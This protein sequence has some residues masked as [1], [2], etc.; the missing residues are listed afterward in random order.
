MWP[1]LK[2][3]K[4]I[5]FLVSSI[6]TNNNP[7]KTYLKSR[8]SCTLIMSEENI[9]KINAGF[10]FSFNMANNQ[11]EAVEIAPPEEKSNKEEITRLKKI[12]DLFNKNDF[13]Q[14][15]HV[16]I[17]GGD[18]DTVKFLLEVGAD[19]YFE[20]CEGETALFSALKFEKYEIA[21]VLI[22]NGFDVN[23]LTTEGEQIVFK[24]IE[25]DYAKQL[26]FLLKKGLDVNLC[27]ESGYKSVPLGCAVEQ[28]NLD[29]IKLF[30]KHGANIDKCD[31][32]GY[33]PLLLSIWHTNG[34][35][36]PKLLV[37]HGADINKSTKS[38]YSPLFR[39]INCNNVDIVKFLIEKGANL[40]CTYE[41][42]NPLEYA[43]H[44]GREK[45]TK[46]FLKK[47]LTF[48]KSKFN[49]SGEQFFKNIKKEFDKKQKKQAAA[50]VVAPVIT[51]VETP[52][53][54][55]AATSGET[56]K[57]QPEVPADYIETVLPVGE[58]TYPYKGSISLIPKFIEEMRKL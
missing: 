40:Q 55:P 44:Y 2:M 1:N 41:N 19:F 7:N 17:E 36:I 31:D 53:A 24:L 38:G 48:D 21:E 52:A 50:N 22:E 54:N 28:A 23:R 18:L 42:R 15:L 32:N 51:P 56:A 35:D 46:L 57:T 14:K 58:K 3:Y 30:L 12:V 49:S 43:V 25:N 9:K 45:L 10:A 33:S 16:A 8:F 39:A 5:E 26:E 47:G 11:F 37:E 20:K 4:T 13:S 29:I 6:I 27:R 34:N